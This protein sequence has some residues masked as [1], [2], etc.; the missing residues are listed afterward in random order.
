MTP[1]EEPDLIKDTFP[2]LRQQRRL[3][4]PAKHEGAGDP[5]CV[6]SPVC[7]F[8]G[9]HENPGKGEQQ[10]DQEGRFR[11]CQAAGDQRCAGRVHTRAGG[12]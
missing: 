3:T 4:A 5:P 8:A 6:S 1:V 2:P 12:D 10:G 11:E 9:C 7:G